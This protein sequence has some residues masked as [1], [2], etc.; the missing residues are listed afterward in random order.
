MA[1]Q[2]EGGRRGPRSP[3]KARAWRAEAVGLIVIVV[4][5]LL[6]IVLRGG[7]NWGAR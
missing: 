6:F 5:I 1:R 3:G 7:V 2:E 4:V